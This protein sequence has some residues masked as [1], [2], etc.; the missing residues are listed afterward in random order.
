MFPFAEFVRDR[1]YG[2][3]FPRVVRE[4][5]TNSKKAIVNFRILPTVLSTV[6][7]FRK[8]M[9]TSF[10]T[11]SVFALPVLLFFPSDAKAQNDSA[12]QNQAIAFLC[13]SHGMFDFL[14]GDWTFTGMRKTSSGVSRPIRGLW[15]ARKSADGPLITDEFRIVNDSGRTTYVSTTWRA[16]QP[17]E[18]RW[19]IIGIEPYVGVPQL[20]SAWPDGSEVR[21]EQEFV[22]G[23]AK[24][25]WRIRYYGIQPNSFLWSADR[26]PDG[27]RSWIKDHMTMRATRN[28]PSRNPATLTH[29]I[30]PLQVPYCK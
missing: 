1:R 23:A 16:I 11:R 22:S 27:G 17:Q 26:S 29:P 25:L 4:I 2:F 5:R 13:R 9:R 20:G 24:A 15:S 18:Q 21:I 7:P 14:L 30:Q 6:H 28:G 10:L 8:P 12:S 3:P 19:T